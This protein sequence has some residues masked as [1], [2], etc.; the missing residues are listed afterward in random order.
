MIM[1]A[2]V[3]EVQWERL[4]VLDLDTRQQV[5]VITPDAVRFRPGDF[6][7]IWYNGVMTRS[8]PPQIYAL[9]I[10]AGPWENFPPVRPSPPVI[11]PPVVFPPV[12]RPPFFPRPPHDH[13]GNRPPHDHPGNRPPHRR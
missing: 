5:L 12:F 7:R 13:P 1:Q 11:S 4:L 8:I 6:V 3:I 2:I 9:R 10:A